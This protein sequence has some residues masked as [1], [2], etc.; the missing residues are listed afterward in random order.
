M[1]V[2]PE[3]NRDKKA[4]FKLKSSELLRSLRKNKSERT[5]IFCNTV[6]SCRDVENFLRRNDRRGKSYNVGC[7]HGALSA[8]K[9][10]QDLA[11]FS[12]RDH[13]MDQILVCTDRAA[14]GVDFGGSIVDH[15]IIFDFPKD[16]AEYIRRVGRTARAGRSGRSTVFA[17]G[18]QLPISRKIMGKKLES[19]TV[20]SS[21]RL[22]TNI[23]DSVDSVIASNIQSGKMWKET[24]RDKQPFY[25][26]N[27][28]E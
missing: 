20:A 15:V 10:N 7:Y 16:P 1:S 8:K 9:R 5:L 21:N 19:F 14:R 11:S 26:Y 13:N 22:R 25:L 23:D 18:W 3:M 4:C 6:E 2:P 27:D 17:Y 24:N 12:K 28:N